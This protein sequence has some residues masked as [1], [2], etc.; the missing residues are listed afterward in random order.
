MK[1]EQCIAR[2]KSLARPGQLA[3]MARYGMSVKNRFGVAVPDLRKLAKEIGRDHAVSL[4]LWR[5]GIADARILAC[6][7]DDPAMV[8]EKQM[9]AWVRNFDSW[10][11]C[12][13]VCMNLFD[14]TPFAWEKVVAWSK[15][16]EEFVRRAAFALIACLAWHDKTEPDERFIE[17]I[18]L[19]KKT[20][21][22]ERNMVKKAVSWALR[23]IGKRNKNL[24]GLAIRTAEELRKTE[25]KS[26]RWIGADALRDLA[27]PVTLRRI[28]KSG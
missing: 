14:K 15:H 9:D 10:D 2:L 28:G 27:S 19:I 17:V 4:A 25:S 16:G 23:H 22:D 8:T 20:A 3:G 26:A 1:P 18:P 21:L 6:M 11:V 12:D 13:Q 24:H 5:T 7:I